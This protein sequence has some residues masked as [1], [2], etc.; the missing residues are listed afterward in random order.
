VVYVLGGDRIKD[1]EREFG[2]TC[3]VG[4]I[5]MKVA[6]LVDFQSIALRLVDWSAVARQGRDYGI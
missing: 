2:E 3:V 6:I 4:A 5:P 1:L